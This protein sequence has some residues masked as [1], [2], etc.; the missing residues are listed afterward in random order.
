MPLIGNAGKLIIY[1]QCLQQVAAPEQLCLDSQAK[2]VPL[3]FG[4][5]PLGDFPGLI[6]RLESKNKRRGQWQTSS[7]VLPRK[8]HGTIYEVI[9]NP[10]S[11]KEGDL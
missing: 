7:D 11:S 10:P 9:R 3:V 2:W 1:S 6:I 8:P 5:E 4:W